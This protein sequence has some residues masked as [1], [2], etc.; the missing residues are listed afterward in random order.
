MKTALALTVIGF[1]SAA[2]FASTLPTR[3]APVK[4]TILPHIA[5][6]IVTQAIGQA[7]RIYGPWLTS[8]NRRFSWLDDAVSHT[9]ARANAMTS[10]ALPQSAYWRQIQTLMANK[11]DGCYAS[12][13][14]FGNEL[15]GEWIALDH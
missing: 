12:V 8:D 15:S 6:E 4:A 5:E 9:V 2:W 1:G 13:M 11:Q 10:P 3:P 14:F 7:P